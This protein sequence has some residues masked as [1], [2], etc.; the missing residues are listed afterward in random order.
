[1][2][3]QVALVTIA[4]IS[5]LI[6]GLHLWVSSVQ[7]NACR[8]QVDTKNA[9]RD[10]FGLVVANRGPGIAYDVTA[11]PMRDPEIDPDD[12]MEAPGVVS[13][14]TEAVESGDI[15]MDVLPA[16]IETT[17]LIGFEGPRRLPSQIRVRVKWKE[18]R[19]FGIKWS[20]G[21]T[22]PVTVPPSV[23]VS[24]PYSTA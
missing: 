15:A 22:I 6:A 20:C 5:A 12:S 3:W 21:Y 13:P 2:S 1:M 19:L 7:H 24:R 18:R 4:C 10:G 17:T 16:D 11:R 8:L 9:G 23:E 14:T